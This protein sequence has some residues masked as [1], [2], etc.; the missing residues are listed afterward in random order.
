MELITSDEN[1][2]YSTLLYT[3]RKSVCIIEETNLRI[4]CRLG[5]FHMV[6]SFL[7]SIGNLMK[8]FG[9]EDLIIQV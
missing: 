4:V 2:I 3:S 9:I 8:G 6:M 7:E 5:G 1:C